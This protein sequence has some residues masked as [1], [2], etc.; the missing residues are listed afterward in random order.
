MFIKEFF[1]SSAVTDHSLQDNNIFEISGLSD[2]HISH[3]N[4]DVRIQPSTP[5]LNT[6]R[7]LSDSHLRHGNPV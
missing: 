4:L 1:L 2:S 3:S 6:D 5:G 7:L